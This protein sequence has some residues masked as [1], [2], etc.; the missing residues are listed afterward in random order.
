M[1]TKVHS[2]AT[3]VI[4]S[5]FRLGIA[6]GLVVFLWTFSFFLVRNS[7]LEKFQDFD[8]LATLLFGASS[9]ALVLVSLAVGAA[10][11]IG[12]QVIEKN[13]ATTAKKTTGLEIE[14]RGRYTTSIGY[15][16]GENARNPDSLEPK[17]REQMGEAFRM[18]QQG[19]DLLKKIE[20]PG[21][22]IA[23]NNLV[24]YGCVY[25]DKSRKD[26]ILKSARHLLEV[27]QEHGSAN[28]MLT[29]CRALL[30]YGESSAEKKNAY[31]I[32]KML[33]VKEGLSAA[34]KKEA[35]LYLGMWKSG[36][37]KSA[38]KSRGASDQEMDQ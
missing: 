1:D 29:A 34:E 9:I 24:F 5:L 32:L 22:Y 19:Y 10:A 14:L 38:A 4:W 16:I 7:K 21:M 11:L 37:P 23:L 15:F 36:R 31:R 26:F 8:D 27:A 12:W 6:L 25:D 35:K 2:R 28:L 3:K 18:A 30:Q 17:D 13:M 33:A 20:G